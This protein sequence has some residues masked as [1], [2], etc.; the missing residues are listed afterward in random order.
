MTFYNDALLISVHRSASTVFLIDP[1]WNSAFEDQCIHRIHRIGQNAKLVRVRKFIV[2][3]SVEEKIVKLQL[4]K[5]EMAK[6]ILND[7]DD[8]DGSFEG[9]GGKKPT[10]A[11]FAELF[12]RS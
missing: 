7:M 6:D 4:R 5:K 1:W 12:G 11:D 10:L 8:D 2:D 9:E 3:D